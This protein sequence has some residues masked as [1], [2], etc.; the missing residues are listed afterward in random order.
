MRVAD[1]RKT[2]AVAAIA[3]LVIAQIA[4]A[5]GA[6]QAS[7]PGSATA[8]PIDGG[9]PRSYV[10][11]RGANLVV[12][13]P[14]VASWNVRERMVAYAAVSYQPVGVAAPSLGTVSLEAT[15]AVWLED[16][17]VRFS[18]IRISQASFG[19]LVRDQVREIVDEI[20]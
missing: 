10:T 18:P 2:I 12:Y 7:P 14:Q 8:S 5:A 16:R 15:T 3:A 11:S 19:S 4:D 17:L 13:Q 1:N 6:R 9:W 20:E